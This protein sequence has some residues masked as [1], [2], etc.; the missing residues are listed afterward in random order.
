MSP[1]LSE[2]GAGKLRF[3][4]FLLEKERSESCRVLVLRIANVVGPSAPLFPDRS[5]PKFMQWLHHQLFHSDATTD[6]QQPPL[7]L[8]RDEFRSYLYIHDLV[9]VLV[10][11]LA[12]KP[13]SGTRLLNVGGEDALSRVELAQKYLA[14]CAT[15]SPEAAATVTRE[16]LPTE[17]AHVDL[18][19]PS[20]LNTRLNTTQLSRL[21]PAFTWTPTQQ[22]L[23]EISRA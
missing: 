2:Y 5:A 1:S 11:L 12:L 6:G 23:H 18:G 22:F 19:Y 7:K 4:Q 8:W 17:R 9:A 21:L 16:I 14:A 10:Q 20:P 3:D 15:R 13:D